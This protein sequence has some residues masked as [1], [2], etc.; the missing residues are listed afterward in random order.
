MEDLNKEANFTEELVY[1][2]NRYSIDNDLNTPDFII[3]QYMV[4]CIKSLERATRTRDEW[5]LPP[6]E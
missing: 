5:T 2:I 4:D 6:Q 1:L 3:A